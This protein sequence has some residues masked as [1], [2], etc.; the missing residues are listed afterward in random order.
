MQT[1]I[2]H[3]Q[4]PCTGKV[5]SKTQSHGKFICCVYVKYTLVD[6]PRLDLAM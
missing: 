4:K 1:Q 6:D 5:S 3:E 2:N